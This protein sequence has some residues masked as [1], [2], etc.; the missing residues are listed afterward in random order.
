MAVTRL[1]YT[2]EPFED[3]WS[4]GDVGPYELLRGTAHF[5]ID[6]AH[7]LNRVVTDIDLAR[8]DD[9]GRAH[10]SADFRLLRPQDPTRG[11]RRLLLD[12][13]NRGNTT[14]MRFDQDGPPAVRGG[15]Y[16]AGDGWLLKRGYT[17]VC[18]GW[19]HDVLPGSD[20]LGI[21][22]PEAIVDGKP[23]AGPVLVEFEPNLPTTQMLLANGLGGSEHRPHPAFDVEDPRATLTVRD[24][25][26]GPATTIDRSRWS[27]ARLDGARAVPDPGH[28]H[29]PDGFV[30][31]KVYEVVY[32]A[33]GSPVSGLGFAAVRDIASHLRF[34]SADQGNPCAGRLDFAL[35]WGASQSGRFL[36]QLLYLGM[37]EDEEERLV[38]DGLLPHIAGGRGNDANTRFSQPAYVGAYSTINLFPF[39]D[40]VQTE[41]VTNRTDGLQSRAI[42]RGKA[43]KVFYTNT[44]VEYWGSQAAL[45]HTALD[46]RADIDP[47]E[48]VRIYHLAGTQHAG[49]P[50][51]LNDTQEATG[52][53]AAHSFN[54]IDYMPLMRAA[55][56]NLDA[57]ATGG[58]Q[59][60]PSRY[61]NL[62]EGTA[63]A[64]SS[65]RQGFSNRV[66]G[67][68]APDHVLPVGR[69]DFGP[70]AGEGRSPELP[71][72][73]AEPYPDL[74]S[75]V[76][77]DGNEVSGIRHPDV[78]VPL[79]TYTGWNRRH[80]DIGGSDHALFL[81]GAT[82]PLS[83]T[84][85]ERQA[86]GDPRPSIDERYGSKAAYLDLLRSCAQEMV[87][88]GYLLAEDVDPIVTYSARRYDE[89]MA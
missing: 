58:Q 82:L 23:V 52:G 51:P 19:Q 11:N 88:Q 33:M 4:F 16:V 36:R 34:A 86:N 74:V 80:P 12:V 76:D 46:G 83:R 24:Y 67:A 71:P 57:W 48:N 73:L 64:R 79:A 63:V 47:P 77:D 53:K 65:V 70:L 40:S 13:P 85:D 72:R 30:P 5:A 37:C 3:G 38:F 60:P 87:S 31:G 42:T 2:T 50:L 39:A 56:S 29:H 62:A 84:A 1:E 9:D 25:A 89:F 14:V 21:R 17:M 69:L 15:E 8:L 32:E 54:S 27:F 26:F 55:L 7:F 28:V 41:P 43:P 81:A 44:S 49:L 61:P 78:A 20:K 35:A 6:P 45:L 10:F 18:C 66:P 75:D 59:P 68:T 22:L